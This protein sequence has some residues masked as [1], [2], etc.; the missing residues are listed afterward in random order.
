MTTKQKDS[1]DKLWQGRYQ[2]SSNKLLEEFSESISFD[3]KLYPYDIAGS[4]AHANMLCAVKL[5]TTAERDSILHGLDTIKAELDSGKFIFDSALEDIHMHIESRL[6]ALVGAPGEKLHTAR[7][8][9][10]QVA[11][12]L[13]LYLR[14]HLH[15]L[16]GLLRELQIAIVEFAKKNFM[17]IIPGYTHMQHAQPVLLA[18]HV[19]AYVEMLQRDWDRLADAT[20]RTNVLP[21]GSGAIAGTSLPIDREMV[22]KELGF[23]AISANSMDAVS[24]RD[25]AVEFLAAA[26]LCGVHLSRMGEDLVLWSSQEFNFVDIDEAYCTGSSMMPQKKNPDVAELVRGKSGRF[27][28]NLMRLLTIMKGLPMTYNRDMQEDK[29]AVFDSVEQLGRAL[30]ILTK[31]FENT[32]VRPLPEQSLFDGD[33][34]YATDIAEYLVRKGVPFRRAHQIV[35][36]LVSHCLE[37]HTG[38]DQVDMET[39]KKFAPQFESDVYLVISPAHGVESK[40]SFGGTSPVNVRKQI[41]EWEK[42]FKAERD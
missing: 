8:R 32:N 39:L 12:D 10:D 27:V 19:L 33:F 35:G 11:L 36:S 34:S 13:R 38:V 40:K 41:S 31:V 15:Q 23:D 22:A 4:R 37:N 18:H 24:D 29:E 42:R 20:K 25:F 7:S 28:G 14:D 16:Q 1:K 9:N 26:A 2:K 6:T 21:L 17:T 3:R 5:L 30:A